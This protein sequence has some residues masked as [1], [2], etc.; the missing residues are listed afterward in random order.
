VVLAF[1]TQRNPTNNTPDGTIVMTN[2]KLQLFEGNVLRAQTSIGALKEMGR[3]YWI[4][5]E[6][7]V[8]GIAQ[9][10]RIALGGYTSETDERIEEPYIEYALDTDDKAQRW[11]TYGT[12]GDAA[13]AYL[14]GDM[15]VNTTTAT[16]A[17][18]GMGVVLR[19]GRRSSIRPSTV[20]RVQ[21][22][23][24]GTTNTAATGAQT[25]DTTYNR[26]FRMNTIRT[27]R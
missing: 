9:Y 17:S 10:E 15:L 4:S 8:E 18:S 12:R 19:S 7:V 27:A 25:T 1:S 14:K 5:F 21:S 2:E 6:T 16:P 20:S 23:A 24:E 13:Y 11:M 3:K 22:T 26:R